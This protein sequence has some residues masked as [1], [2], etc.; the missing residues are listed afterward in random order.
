MTKRKI[1]LIEVCDSMA[2]ACGFGQAAAANTTGK[3]DGIIRHDADVDEGF[4]KGW[5]L[6]AFPKPLLT[7]TGRLPRARS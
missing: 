2:T 4:T 7:W 3:S 5:E 1:G 6:T